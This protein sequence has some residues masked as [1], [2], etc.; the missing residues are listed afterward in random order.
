MSV[1]ERIQSF[2]LSRRRT[3]ERTWPSRKALNLYVLRQR[4][5]TTYKE[6]SPLSVDCHPKVGADCVA[7]KVFV[8]LSE[9]RI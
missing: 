7:Y 9:L 3:E 1:R 6:M 2:T 8:Q 4:L 5:I